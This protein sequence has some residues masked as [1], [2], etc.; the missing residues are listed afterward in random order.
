MT[1]KAKNLI[2]IFLFL[3]CGTTAFIGY[4]V[5]TNNLK[6][7]RLQQ[8]NTECIFEKETALGKLQQCEQKLE[9]EQ[10]LL[11]TDEEKPLPKTLILEMPIYEQT[12]RASC[13]SASTHLV[14]SY[15]GTDLSENKII[16]EIGADKSSRYRDDDGVLHWGNP[17]E[18]FVG[19]I[20]GEHIYY[21]GYGVYNQP[22]YNVL[23]N[24]GFAASISQ[25]EWTL[26]ELYIQLLQGNPIIAWV[27]NDFKKHETEIMIA[28]DGTEN[29]YMV[30]EHAVVLYGISEKYVYIADVG[31][32]KYK[33]VTKKEFEA[34][35]GNLNNMAIVVKK[36][37]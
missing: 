19:N 12:H 8:T 3:L 7:T 14:M 20:D 4:D 27:S 5:Y 36:G 23:S 2:I 25:T 6:R 35:F 22:I 24:H 13:E 10:E 31:D 21:D 17:Q 29:L 34:G 30:R 18:K 1:T 26:D 33:K 37:G 11:K 16:E 28:S 15:F 9:N 32:G